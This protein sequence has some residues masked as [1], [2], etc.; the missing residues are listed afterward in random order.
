MYWGTSCF[1][2]TPTN[3]LLWIRRRMVS[4]CKKNSLA[5][6]NWSYFTQIIVHF[7]GCFGNRSNVHI[8]LPK[9][10]YRFRVCWCTNT[11]DII[12]HD[13][14]G[15]KAKKVISDSFFGRGKFQVLRVVGWCDDEGVFE[16]A[17]RKKLHVLISKL[18]LPPN[19]FSVEAEEPHPSLDTNGYK[20]STKQHLSI[21]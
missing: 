7:S 10:I 16:S 19:H 20:T 9:K 8:S 15:Y 4:R 14:E 17:T 21:V 11:E 3:F 18:R 2:M 12:S 6:C 1:F 5:S 13:I